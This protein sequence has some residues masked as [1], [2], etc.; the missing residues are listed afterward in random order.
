MVQLKN[1]YFLATATYCAAIYWLSSQSD[2]PIPKGT[3]FTL[4]GADKIVHGAIF[5]GLAA[6]LSIGIRRSNSHP[7]AWA[8]WY[9]PV[10]FVILYGISDEWHQAFVP[11]RSPDLRDVVADAVGGTLAQIALYINWGRARNNGGKSDHE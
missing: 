1:T 6:L 9:A 4:P 10:V 5:A 7:P 3:L 11:N 2:L 8:Q